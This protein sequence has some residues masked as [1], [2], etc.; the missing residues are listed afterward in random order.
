[1]NILGE[2][3][4]ILMSN[5]FVFVK[6]KRFE[7]NEQQTNDMLKCKNIGVLIKRN[8]KIICSYDMLCAHT[9]CARCKSLRAHY[10]HLYERA[11]NFL[12]PEL[13]TNC[14]CF[15]N[16]RIFLRHQLLAS[17]TAIIYKFN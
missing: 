4:Q 1:M 14:F 12:R 6:K 8:S 10:A 16:F 2:T 3:K 5:I 11:R 13:S 17:E 9:F 15:L 7:L